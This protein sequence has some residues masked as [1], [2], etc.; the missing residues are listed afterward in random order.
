MK[1]VSRMLLAGL[2]TVMA[3][4]ANAQLTFNV[5][6]DNTFD[7][8]LTPPIV[9]TGTFTLASDPG[10]GTFA[11]DAI[12]PVLDFTINGVNFT[13]AD[14]MSDTSLVLLVLS[15]YSATQRRLQFSD[16]GFGGGGPNGGSIDFANAGGL[17]SFEPSY[18]GAG[19]NLYFDGVGSGSYLALSG[20]G[21]VP[22]PGTLALL[23]GMGVVGVG[24]LRRRK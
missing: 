6:F 16:T 18:V 8:T 24:I 3:A 19:L 11:F 15:D 2:L 9:G 12:S 20:T 22:E 21:D 4:A 5:E 23:A 13:N 14:I 1:L 17:I 7:G 10:N